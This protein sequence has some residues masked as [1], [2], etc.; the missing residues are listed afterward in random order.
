MTELQSADSNPKDRRKRQISNR[1]RGRIVFWIFAAVIMI[2][3]LWINHLWASE[4]RWAEIA[5]EM[6]MTGDWFHPSI[7]GEVYF[8]KPL[9]SY[10]PIVMF[11]KIFQGINEFV[12]RLPSALAALLALYCTRYF[13]WKLFNKTVGIAAGWILLASFGFI[14]QGRIA[15]ADMMNLTAVIMAVS[16]FF[17]CK[18]HAKFHHYLIF[19]IICF[20]GAMT[21]GLPALV[22][23]PLLV[24]AYLFMA[25]DWRRHIN[26]A[27]IIA[28]IIGFG[29][30]FLTFYIASTTALPEGF[31]SQTGGLSGLELVWRENVVRVFQPFDH[32]DEP[33]FSYFY[34]MPRIMAPWALLMVAAIVA[35]AWRWKKLDL[36]T[37]WLLVA[38]A[39]IFVMFTISGSRRWYYIL[40]IMPFTAILIGEYICAGNRFKWQ[41]F[42]GKFHRG[43][44]A[45]LSIVGILGI[46]IL[47]VIQ[48]VKIPVP[49]QAVFYFESF[50]S[51]PWIILWSI[52]LIS[53]AC[54]FVLVLP[55]KLMRKYTGLPGN[56]AGAIVAGALFMFAALSVV[57][58]EAGRLRSE[59]PFALELKKALHDVAP[60]DII[61]YPKTYPKLIFYMD[62]QSPAVVLKDAEE[63]RDYMSQSVKPKYLIT[64]TRSG[65]IKDISEVLP[66]LPLDK[67]DFQE[68]AVPFEEPGARKLRC[69]KIEPAKES[70]KK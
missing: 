65:I 27:H 54:A 3:G 12:S 25:K 70:T 57:Y 6:L 30:Y 31:I 48:N 43:L 64:E 15:A 34:H 11:A 39:I 56:W 55:G 17:Y 58:P 14:F 20:C 35:V 13:G 26:P 9:L 10:W 44:F 7:N 47:L 38:N 21:K 69:W 32:D 68:G 28:F 29:V 22:I 4:D 59:K 40:P 5:R 16:W 61:F 60:E 2:Y 66:E 18:D 50:K 42:M 37:R 24:V 49:E 1:K 45:V 8:D 53:V 36:N 63:L 51:L 41:E 62:L 46:V 19:W 67:P 23:P 33:F 52:P